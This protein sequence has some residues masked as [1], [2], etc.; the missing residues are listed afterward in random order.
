MIETAFSENHSPQLVGDFDYDAIDERVFGVLGKEATEH[1]RDMAVE[2]AR[3]WIAW[4]FN[5]TIRKGVRNKSS[6]GLRAAA[7]SWILL[8]EIHDRYSLTQFSIV[9]KR[10][11]QSMGRFVADFKK[12]FPGVHNRHMR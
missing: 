3:K 11:K 7:L 9:L 4:V 8:P 12:T 10:D 2:L 6:I 1:Q 5:D